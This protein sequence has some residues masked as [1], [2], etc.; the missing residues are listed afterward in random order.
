MNAVLR[1]HPLGIDTHREFVIYMR[2]DCHVCRS[3]G[4]QAQTRVQVAHGERVMLDDRL[5]PAHFARL[6]QLRD[7]V[8]GE[9]GRET[10]ERLEG[11][12]VTRLDPGFLDH[13][14]RTR[15]HGTLGA[16]QITLPLGRENGGGEKQCEDSGRRT[17]HLNISPGAGSDVV[18]RIQP[19]IPLRP[20]LTGKKM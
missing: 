9:R 18:I 5:H 12:D 14:E 20:W 6:P 15:A 17:F 8:F 1:L 7:L 4:F 2:R 10:T 13:A 19:L 16:D 3:E 11:G